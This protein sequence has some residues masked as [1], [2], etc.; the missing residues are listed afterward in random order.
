MKH[1][2]GRTGFE[3]VAPEH[4]AQ[5]ADGVL[6]RGRRS[7]RRLLAPEEV[8]QPVRRDYAPRFQHEDREKRALLGTSERD[9]PG[10]VRDL[11]RA[12]YPVV[13]RHARP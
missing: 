4:P 13:Q 3:N 10:L 8:D 1:V 7:S 5:A 12:E 11:E 2:P 9:V 6:E